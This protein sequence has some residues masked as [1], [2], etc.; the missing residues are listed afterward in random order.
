MM[1]QVKDVSYR[2]GKALLLASV[3]VGFPAGCVTAL[4]GPNGA[5]KSTLL[6]VMAGDIKPDRGSVFYDQREIT[7]MP[8]SERAARRAV[9]TQATTLN[10]GYP[11]QDVVAMSR[12]LRKGTA[13]EDRLSIVQAMTRTGTLAFAGRDVRQLSGGQQAR[14]LMARVLAQDTQ[15][16]LLDEPAAAL[17]L[18]H[19]AELLRICREE[20]AQG[21]TVVI[22][23][24]DLN[25][26][27]L[28]A[29]HIV[30]MKQGRVV[31]QGGPREIATPEKLTAIYG[32]PVV[33][34]S[35]PLSGMPA[36]L[37]EAE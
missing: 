26:A 30:I 16:L 5:G 25:L 3:S 27:C 34:V 37:M 6:S 36:V 13:E 1:L 24:H 23:L 33:V 19:Q 20:A 7:G 22:I 31:S 35:H 11:V 9:F 4:L 18:H 12:L 28:F 14:V 15:V 8:L 29:D 32:E 21:K 17:D 2:R 10:Y